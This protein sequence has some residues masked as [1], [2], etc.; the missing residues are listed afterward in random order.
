MR[1]SSITECVKNV[2]RQIFK[3]KL[4][5]IYNDNICFY[6]TSIIRNVYI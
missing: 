1:E 6:I 4:E 2:Q 5:N 3:V